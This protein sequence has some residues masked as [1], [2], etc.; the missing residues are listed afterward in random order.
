MLPVTEG[1]MSI[2]EVF[3]EIVRDLRQKRGLSQEELAGRCGLHRN[4]VGLLER[5]E[6]IPSI[7]T[8]FALAHGLDIKPSTLIAKLEANPRSQ[9]WLPNI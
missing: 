2:S 9:S 3:G 1:L 5:G 6:R 8:V 7:E 4:A